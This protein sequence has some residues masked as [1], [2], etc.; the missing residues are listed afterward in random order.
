MS[1]PVLDAVFFP[2][3]FLGANF[4]LVVAL[5]VFVNGEDVTLQTVLTREILVTLLAV[6]SLKTEKSRVRFFRIRF[7]FSVDCM[8]E[9]GRQAG[10]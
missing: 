2:Q 4:A 1:L 7:A 3:E 6:E 8:E 10:M 5:E 9:I